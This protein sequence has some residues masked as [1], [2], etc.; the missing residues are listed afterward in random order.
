VTL[1]SLWCGSRHLQTHTDWWHFELPTVHDPVRSNQLLRFSSPK[2]N[3]F[4]CMFYLEHLQH[5]FS[6]FHVLFWWFYCLKCTQAWHPSADLVFWVLRRLW[7]ALQRKL[8]YYWNFVQAWVTL[9]LDMSSMSVII[10]WKYYVLMYKNGKLTCWNC[11]RNEGEG[12][13]GEW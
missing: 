1:A 9:L 2:V 3:R 5:S 13:K 7:C 11:C 4:L 8:R 10:W 12:N 6:H